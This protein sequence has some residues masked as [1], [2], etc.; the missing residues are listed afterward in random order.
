MMEMKAWQVL[1]TTPHQE[2]QKKQSL[3]TKKPPF[4][5]GHSSNIYYVDIPAGY[6]DRD[7]ELIYG[8]Q[9]M[10]SSNW[11]SCQRWYPGMA[12]LEEMLWYPLFFTVNMW[13]LLTTVFFRAYTFNIRPRSSR[14]HC[15]WSSRCLPRGRHRCLRTSC[16]YGADY[17]MQEKQR[18][19][20]NQRNRRR[21]RSRE[22][23]LQYQACKQVVRLGDLTV[24]W[25]QT[26]S[27][28]SRRTIGLTRL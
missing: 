5:N 4:P 17:L 8:I 19:E 21:I 20:C 11:T 28:A 3:T 27:N 24:R 6:I 23:N 22:E 12:W 18:L 25:Q 26:K 16:S 7:N 2:N 10:N 14:S 13:Q 1:S 9:T 15:N